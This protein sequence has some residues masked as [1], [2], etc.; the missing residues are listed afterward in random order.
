LNLLEVE[1]L[2]LGPGVKAINLELTDPGNNREPILGKDAAAVW[3]RVLPAVAGTEPWALDFFS[4]LDRVRNYCQSKDIPYR[5]ASEH[6]IVIAPP[7]TGVLEGFFE[8]FERE[9][10]GARAGGGVTAGDAA[11][12]SAIARKGVD[13]YAT[14]FG[15]YVFCG[16]CDFENGSLVLLTNKLWAS[17]VL[18]RIKPVLSDIDIEVRLPK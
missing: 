14:A 18:R 7:P 13:A 9:R 2:D 10:F 11:L 12:E 6:A 15:A 4:H 3:S 17:E 5:R 16:V 1:P 8:R